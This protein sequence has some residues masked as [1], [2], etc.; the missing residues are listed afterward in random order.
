MVFSSGFFFFTST[1]AAKENNLSTI[2]SLIQVVKLLRGSS[3]T[4]ESYLFSTK[5]YYWEDQP[6]ECPKRQLDY[7]SF[8][9]GSHFVFF[10]LQPGL[11]WQIC[12]GDG[13]RICYH[14]LSSA[15]RGISKLNFLLTQNTKFYTEMLQRQIASLGTS[16]NSGD[17]GRG[18]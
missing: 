17:G 9:P 6:L 1:M 10:S 5:L 2:V 18:V 4:G 3:S 16:S 13:N 8:H 14:K 7:L 12:E 15:R 11:I